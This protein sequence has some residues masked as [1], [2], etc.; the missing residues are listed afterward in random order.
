MELIEIL[1]ADYERFPENQTYSIYAP[2]VYFK[3]P[4]TEFRGLEKYQKMID[5]IR[6]WFVAVQFDVHDLAQEGGEILSRWTLSWTVPLFWRP[7]VS[8]SG[9]SQLQVNSENLIIS[10]IDDWDC[11]RLDVL[12]QLF[13]ASR[14]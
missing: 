7:R 6:Q 9:R 5:F 8:I 4:L 12:K 2:D 13:S 14:N 3:D 1:K 10:H 11:S